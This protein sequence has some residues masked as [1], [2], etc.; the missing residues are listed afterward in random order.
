[1]QIY[2]VKEAKLELVEEFIHNNEMAIGKKLTG[3]SY[4]IEINGR[5]EGC[6]D[7][8]RLDESTYWLKQLHLNKEHVQKLFVVFESVLIIAR[9]NNIKCVY[10]HNQSPVVDILL[11]SLQFKR[12]SDVTFKGIKSEKTGNWWAYQVS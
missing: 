2:Q 6:F 1:M 4:V 3:Q 5:I 10:V 9:K 8:E 12:E 7:L 11:E